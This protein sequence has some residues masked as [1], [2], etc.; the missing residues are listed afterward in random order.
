[1]VEE[2]LGYL[3]VAGS[4]M[5]VEVEGQQQHLAAALVGQVA[6]VERPVGM[7][8]LVAL[9]EQPGGMLEQV[10]LVEQPVGMLEQVALVGMQALV[11]PEEQ[12]VG[13]KVLEEP[14][15][16]RGQV[17]PVGNLLQVV[18]ALILHFLRC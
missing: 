7:L 2:R 13:R 6:L 3:P 11:V 4:G 18:P 16:I 17:V 1:M 8:E 15:G 12:P 14:V 9:V 5:Q 10:A